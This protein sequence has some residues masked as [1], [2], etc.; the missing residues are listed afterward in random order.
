VTDYAVTVVRPP[1]Y[2]HARAVDEIAETLSV[3]L[4]AIG[5]DALVTSSGTIEGRQHIVLGA[6]LLTAY[7]LPIAS[8]AI[9]YNLEQIAPGSP[10]FDIA[11]VHLLRQFRVWDYSDL[12]ATAAMLLGIKVERVVPIGYV[13]Q[14]TRIAARTADVDVLFIGSMNPR[15]TK[16]LNAL[17]AAGLTVVALFGV[18]GR[19]RDA[20]IAGARLVINIHFYE[21]KVLEMVRLSYLL[22][23]ACAVLSESSADE[24]EDAGLAGGVEFA[25]YGELVRRARALIDDVHAREGLAQRG[26]EIFSARREVDYLRAALA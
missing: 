9:L 15:R 25:P 12:N 4:H 26:F 14:L 17:K 3:G 22:A 24:T 2:L 20:Y 7:P 6:N 19:E 16:V 18:Y 10:W 1:G 5:H 11:M 21:A 23:N 8:D 13:P